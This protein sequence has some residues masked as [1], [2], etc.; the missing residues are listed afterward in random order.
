MTLGAKP[1]PWDR[2]QS[3]DRRQVAPTEDWDE[4]LPADERAE[5]LASQRN[6]D[7]LIEEAEE[8]RRHIS[9]DREALS[10]RSNARAAEAKRTVIPPGQN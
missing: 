9:T 2:E 7:E 4:A 6:A 5:Y 10:N 3:A 8:R 1:S